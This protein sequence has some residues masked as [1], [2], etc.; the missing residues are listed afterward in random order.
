[1]VLKP[2]KNVLHGSSLWPLGLPP[3]SNVK[4]KITK[5]SKK[6][7]FLYLTIAL[8]SV[9]YLFSKYR[10]TDKITP[11]I[12]G[13]IH[14]LYKNEIYASSELIFPHVEQAPV[15]K[16]LTIKGL[17]TTRTDPNNVHRLILNA[18]DVPMS[19]EEKKKITNQV[20]LVKKSFLDH[21]K[22]VYPQKNGPKVIIVTL[23]DF[24]RMDLDTI[25]SVV[26][27]RVDYAQRNN[28]GIYVRWIQEFV[29]LLFD[30]NLDTNSEY[31]RVLVM[32]AAMHAFP[33]A[34]KF[35]FIEDNSLISNFKLKIENNILN[36]KTLESSILKGVT[37]SKDATIKTYTNVN[38]KDISVIIPQDNDNNLVLS[39]FI[40]TNDLYGKVFLEYIGD[41]LIREFEWDNGS[42]CVSHVLQWHPYLL[43]HTAIVKS[44]LL[45]SEYNPA[46]INS[47]SDSEFFQFK[48]FVARFKSCKM[49]NTCDKDITALFD[50][51]EKNNA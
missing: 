26:Q 9:Y 46:A 50:I 36:P 35:V 32:R 16:E 7:I 30:Q 19:D 40:V 15:L 2:R 33:N 11:R 43:K 45:A 8:L 47:E 20:S 48:D 27:N 3:I 5:K 18:D 17:F 1:M 4:S 49:F 38:I 13:P 31:C 37:L 24:E 25:V 23:I 29:P 51:L 34:E 41:T 12:Y 22:L 6:S 14:G 10:T 28:Y 42:H 44:K 39:T 21:G